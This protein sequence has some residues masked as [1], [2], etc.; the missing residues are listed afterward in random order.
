MKPDFTLS[1]EKL[2]RD[3]LELALSRVPAYD[4]W[5]EFDPGNSYPANKRYSMLPCLSKADLRN[6][7]WKKFITTDKNP[8]QALR[9]GEISLVETSG[10]TEEKVVN[11]W[12]QPWWDA[13]E[14]LSWQYNNHSLKLIGG[15]HR[16]SI[17]TSSRNTG[18]ASDDRWLTLTERTS[19]RFTYLNERSG[20]H[21]WSRELMNRMLDELA[22][23]KPV[24]LE[25][26]PMYLARLALFANANG[27]K[28]YQPQLIILTYENA[29]PR[30]RR[31]IRL[32]FDSPIASSYG[33]TESGYVLM[34]CEHGLFHQVSE[35]CRID[36]E[37][38]KSEHGK[39]DCG[40][41]FVTTFGNPW[42]TLIRYDIGDMVRLCKDQ[43][44]ACGRKN[45]YIVEA[46]LG[47]TANITFTTHGVPRTSWEVE[48]LFS[49][50][51]EIV[52]YKVVQVSADSYEAAIE[53]LEEA[54]A[55]G[56][57]NEVRERLM[58]FYGSNAHVGVSIEPFIDCETSGKYRTT[59]AM[60]AHNESDLF[61]KGEAID[62]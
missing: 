20:P 23:L 33:S 59:R 21:M 38:F 35:S 12:Y 15:K 62:E 9:S 42:R 46:I 5:K 39:P 3:T 29:S 1:F 47:R 55:S 52:S 32:S 31:L 40:R 36:F 25:A 49:D 37:P 44:C 30:T 51:E 26:N 6:L 61:E 45:G 2:S 57:K 54:S 19:G 50:I 8:D 43:S 24:T 4:L 11:A 22:L 60:F 58:S 14:R 7:G 34:E 16:E 53:L 56:T 27:I 48:D 28:P 10:T 13:S 18:P 17:L 41:I